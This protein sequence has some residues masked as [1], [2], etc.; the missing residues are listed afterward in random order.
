MAI[1][2]IDMVFSGIAYVILVY[3]MIRLLQ[4]K[5]PPSKGEDGGDGG[6]TTDAVPPIDLPPGIVPP[7]HPVTY[8]KESEPEEALS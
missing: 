8:K 1:P 6:V 7:G 5:T 4:R 2:F 3:F